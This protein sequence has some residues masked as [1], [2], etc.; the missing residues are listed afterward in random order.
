MSTTNALSTKKF[1]RD[2]LFAH[3]P[4]PFLKLRTYLWLVA[5][6]H[7]LGVAGY[8]VWSLFSITLS[9]AVGVASLN[10][11]S[12]M[13]RFLGGERSAEELSAAW[14]TVL[15]TGLGVSTLAGLG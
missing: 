13:M 8:G 6:A 4:L 9:M 5:F 1:V 12:A 3:L 2:T 14:S 7:C 10:L 15:C 11:G